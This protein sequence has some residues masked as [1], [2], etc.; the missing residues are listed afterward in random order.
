MSNRVKFRL[1][2]IGLLVFELIAN[3]ALYFFDDGTLDPA[4]KLLPEAANWYT[5]YESNLAATIIVALLLIVAIIASIVGVLLFRNW[6]RWLYLA[7]SLLVLL[8]SIVNG[9]A[10]YYA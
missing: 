1:A 9:A 10:I 2:V 6:G 4:W 5:Y 7:S 8:V 3:A